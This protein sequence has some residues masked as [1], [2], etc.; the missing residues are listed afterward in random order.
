MN[1]A[2]SLPK[3]LQKGVRFSCTQCGACCTGAPGRVRVSRA[4]AETIAAFLGLELEEWRS[5]F[6]RTD[7]DGSWLLRE[8]AKGDCVFFAEN[9]C[10]IH[11]VKPGQCRRY[12][13]WFRNVRNEDAWR[14]TV[15]ECPGIGEGP[16]V[17]PEEILRIVQEDLEALS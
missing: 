4:E 17:E 16:L 15:E 6:V 14:K 1:P 8:N 2:D 13:F 5:R 7:E 10:T 12:P 9:R 3:P 11:E